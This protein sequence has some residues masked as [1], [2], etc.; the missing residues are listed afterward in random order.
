MKN[1]KIPICLPK[2]KQRRAL[3]CYVI[4]IILYGSGCWVISPQMKKSFETIEMWFHR[5]LLRITWSEH[6]SNDEVLTE[7]ETNRT[8]T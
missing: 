1:Q 4:P 7:I 3:G 8:Q 6:M 5:R 2:A